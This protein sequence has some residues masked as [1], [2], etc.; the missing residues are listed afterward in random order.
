MSR[1]P[2]LLVATFFPVIALIVMAVVVVVV[3]R[4]LSGSDDA[5]SATIGLTSASEETVFEHDFVIPAGTGERIV[6]GEAVDVVPAE[7]TVRVGDAIRI[8]NH[9]AR[10]HQVGVFYVGAGESLTQR[11]TSPGRLQ[12]RCD[13]HSSKAFTLIVLPAA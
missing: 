6:A 1:T 10:G 8:V 12:D 9:D 4:G 7:L 5:S 2:R 3:A 13:V 11:F